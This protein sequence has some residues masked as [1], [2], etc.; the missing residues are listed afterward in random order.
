[1]KS[2]GDEK[3]AHQN[4]AR[5]ASVLNVLTEG[6]QTGLRLTDVANTTGLSKAVAHRLLAGMIKYGLV[7][8]EEVNGRYFL[9]L[10]T[11]IWGT[12]AKN[13]Y[14][15]EHILEPALERLC[16]KTEDTVYLMLRNENTC[17]CI[18]R[19]EGSYPIKTL[20]MNVGDHR[21]LGFG[22][23]PLAI[24]SFLP[25]TDVEHII[26]ENRNEISRFGLSDAD[27]WKLI[28]ETRTR[29]YLTLN[30]GVTPGM[31]CV[32]IPIRRRDGEAIAAIN[33]VAVSNRMTAERSEKVAKLLLDEIADIEVRLG[34]IGLSIEGVNVIRSRSLK[35]T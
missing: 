4:V 11:V 12:K 24:L 26:S 23:G 19:H 22:A 2:S 5:M 32:A 29:G 7:D 10:H 28:N 35:K 16:K 6:A 8:Y 20:T 25:D 31:S 9:G 3:G 17:C 33:I 30:E 18:S 1:M 14:G 27:I 34:S 21:A 15:L 13:R